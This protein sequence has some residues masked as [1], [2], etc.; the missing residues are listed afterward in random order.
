MPELPE[1]ETIRIGLEPII[2]GRVITDVQVLHPRAV[3][4]ATQGLEP[5]RDM[6]IEAVVRRGKFLWFEAGNVCL[7]AHLGMSGQFRV[8]GGVQEHRRASL[9]LDD[10]VRL[11]FV[12]QRTFGHLLPDDLIQTPDGA[13]GGWGSENDRLPRSV[14]HIGRDPLDPVFDIDRVA[15]KV[16]SKNTE[17]K[18]ALLDQTLA[19]GIGNIYADEALFLARV[20]PRRLTNRMSVAK[21]REVYLA[22]TAVMNSALAVGGTSFDELY[23]NVNGASGYFDRSLNVYGREG[24][25][26][27]VCGTPIKRE[28]FMNRSSHFCP[29]CQRPRN[30]RPLTQPSR[31]K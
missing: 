29:T 22:A 19:S 28:V 20:H 14:A 25:P 1:V 30:V 27:P 6:R 13:P 3:R 9:T 18:R 11:D 2:M 15:R 5:I 24:S 12:D 23:V 17:I 21:I 31:G 10:G 8:G 7:I 4:R 26:C 16:K